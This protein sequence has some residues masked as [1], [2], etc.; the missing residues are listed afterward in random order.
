[1]AAPTAS[2]RAPAATPAAVAARAA[3]PSGAREDPRQN[4]EHEQRDEQRGDAAVTRFARLVVAQL[5]AVPLER[6]SLFVGDPR[7]AREHALRDAARVVAL[8][9]PRRDLLADDPGLEPVRQR[10]LEPIAR[11]EPHLVLVE[12]HEHQE[13][14]VLAL[15]ADLPLLEHLDL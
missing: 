13:P 11:L 10:A 7:R 6:H 1:A 5:A 12:R 9:K 15:L 3:Q 14:V 2:E 4:D 8:A